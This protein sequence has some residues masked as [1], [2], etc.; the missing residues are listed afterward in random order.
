MLHKRA[1]IFGDKRTAEARSIS[2]HP[3]RISQ[4]SFHQRPTRI[5]RFEKKRQRDN[6]KYFEQHRIS[7]LSHVLK[8]HLEFSALWKVS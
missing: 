2:H 8:C 3:S 7:Y 1:D 5:Q 6:S 4:P